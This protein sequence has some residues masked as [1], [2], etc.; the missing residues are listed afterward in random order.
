MSNNK[1]AESLTE[2]KNVIVSNAQDAIINKVTNIL[3]TLI[4]PMRGLNP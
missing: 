2:R 4:Q 1:L 3:K